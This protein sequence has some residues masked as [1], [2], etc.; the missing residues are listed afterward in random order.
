MNVILGK[1][2]HTVYYNHISF[3][4]PVCRFLNNNPLQSLPDSTFVNVSGIQEL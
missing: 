3:L 2:Q 4:H 1:D